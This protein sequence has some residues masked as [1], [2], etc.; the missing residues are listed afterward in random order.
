MNKVMLVGRISNDLELRYTNNNNAVVEFSLATNRPVMRDG[1][2]VTDFITC[3][4]FGKQAENLQKYQS[5]GNLIG[6]EGSFRTDKYQDK[7][8]NNRYKNY[9]LV[10]IVE[11]LEGNRGASENKTEEVTETTETKVSDDV[12]REFGEQIQISDDEL[13][14]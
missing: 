3:V 6:I 7:D 14:F 11:F 2:R 4:L 13:P 1:E 5:K 8:G 12:F 9:V 10:N